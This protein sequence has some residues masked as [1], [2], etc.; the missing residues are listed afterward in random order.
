MDNEAVTGS[1]KTGSTQTGSTQTGTSITGISKTGGRGLKLAINLARDF[2]VPRFELPPEE[3]VEVVA[4]SDIKKKRRRRGRRDTEA[5]ALFDGAQSPPVQTEPEPLRPLPTDPRVVRRVV[6]AAVVAVLIVVGTVLGTWFWY[7]QESPTVTDE[8]VVAV[9]GESSAAL[10]VALDSQD[11]AISAGVMTSNGTDDASLVVFPGALL[12]EIPGFGSHQLADAHLLGGVDSV[13]HALMNEL[14]ILIDGVAVLS[15]GDLAATL[16]RDLDVTLTAP[17]LEPNFNGAVVTAAEGTAS[18]SPEEIEAMLT[19]PGTGGE[20]DFLQRQRAVW[21]AYF[22]ELARSPGLVDQFGEEDESAVRTI[23]LGLGA[24]FLTATVAPVRQV[25]VGGRELLGL[26]DEPAFYDLHFAGI[27]QPLNP[28]PR[29]EILNGTFEV[30]ITQ[31]VAGDLIEA[32][33]WVLRTDNADRA[34]YRETLVISQGPAGQQE[35]VLVQ[36]RL[37]FGEI[38]IEQ[39]ASGSVDVSVILGADAIN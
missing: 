9:V 38:V 31:A 21:E 6:A 27:Q 37:G 19:T 16:D 11:R 22:L 28:R 30:G 24:D 36:N 20:I 10:V 1:T 33:F 39:S 29:V 3:P 34:S 5:P 7:N 2:D 14:G 23:K 32:G 17:F 35:A 25:G 15:P 8:E 26:V 4:A 18:Y 13:R 12:M